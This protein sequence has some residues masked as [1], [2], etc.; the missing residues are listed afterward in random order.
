MRK[1]PPQM[2]EIAALLIAHQANAQSGKNL[3]TRTAADVCD[4]LRPMLSMLMGATGFRT[5]LTRALKLASAE[6]P[7][8]RA[9]TVDAGGSLVQV[10]AS[11]ANA[12][13]LH[14]TDGGAVLVAQLLSLLVAFIGDTLTVQLLR[15]IWPRIPAHDINFRTGERK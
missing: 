10:D 12:A 4:E 15:D 1:A 6:A 14:D 13:S 8:L 11:P 2:L 5:L 3:R 7:A 9:L